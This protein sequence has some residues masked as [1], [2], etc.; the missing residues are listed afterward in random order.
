MG[1]QPPVDRPE[2]PSLREANLSLA[3]S[4]SGEGIRSVAD[5]A[6]VR[7]L[8]PPGDGGADGQG[9]PGVRA[10]IGAAKAGAGV[11]ADGIGVGGRGV[12]LG[13]DASLRFFHSGEGA[14]GSELGDFDVG[15]DAEGVEHGCELD[16]GG[17]REARLAPEPG[18]AIAGMGIELVDADGDDD[19]AAGVVDEFAEEVGDIGR[20]VEGV[21]ADDDIG[22]VDGGVL[23]VGG[24]GRDV[25]D[26]AAGGLFF[27]GLAH[28]GGGL[29]GDDGADGGG[30]GEGVAAGAGADIE[31]GVGGTD[32]GGEAVA[33]G[34]GAGVGEHGTEIGGAGV[35]EALRGVFE[36]GDEA[37][38]LEVAG[39][40]HVAPGGG[41]GV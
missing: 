25:G 33:E 4:S 15:G 1:L 27:E 13:G 19:G 14:A 2:G 8:L 26:V 29:H 21:G 30:D 34:I 12:D 18:E 32:E 37:A 22:G 17:L 23:P 10:V 7:R 3:L 39:T 5:S 31:H 20:G 11:G 24:D 38:D 36:A 16:E 40:G 28:G 9:R 6:L 35:P 41:E